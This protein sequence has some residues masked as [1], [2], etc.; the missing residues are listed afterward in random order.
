MRRL[1][2]AASVAALMLAGAQPGVASENPIGKTGELIARISQPDYSS[3]PL[4]LVIS[5]DDQK[6]R[7]YRGA[8]V[9][10]ESRVSSGKRGYETPTGVF[11]ILH[12]KKF[13]RSNIYAGAPMP[14]MQRLTWTGIALHGSS[15]VPS[16]PASHG[17]I[18][19]PKGFDSQLFSM[20]QSGIHVVI[21]KQFREPRR[22]DHPALPQPAAEPGYD[23]RN[24]HWLVAYRA[25]GNF[26]SDPARH[27]STAGLLAPV[28]DEMGVSIIPRDDSQPVR[29]LISRRSQSEILAGVQ[30]VLNRL[31]FDA[32]EV[33]GRFG[34][35]T[36]GAIKRFQEANEMTVN[37]A[38][39]PD[40]ISALYV[41]AGMDEPK[42]AKLSVRYKF[43]QVLETG[44]DITEPEKPLGTHLLLTSQ[45]DRDRSSTQWMSYTLN[46]KINAANRA[47]YGI[48]AE[49]SDQVALAEALDRIKM[50]ANVYR[51]L[52]SIL[53]PGSS[54]MIADN[55]TERY[56]GWKSDFTVET[57]DY[58]PE[59][60]QNAE[61]D[62]PKPTDRVASSG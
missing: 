35:A 14:F 54:I 27:V 22:I 5:L 43:E 45:F 11:S 33:D 49:A 62:N 29:I 18:R 4:Q 47:F 34:P 6:L 58:I 8:E 59:P 21:A 60:S 48:D 50:P 13:H 16:F 31:G 39:T 57:K 32:G 25:S 7:A 12:K 46:N 36:R 20:T 23:A 28:R 51:L 53:T 26:E 3:D 10:A 19:L 2:C 37:G 52:T 42:N 56:T 40:L 55:G 9:V 30:G 24:D 41:V 38:L 17:C 44:I 15:S 61:A 1:I